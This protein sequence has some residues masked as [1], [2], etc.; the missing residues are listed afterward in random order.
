MRD[1]AD[2]ILVVRCGRTGGPEIYGMALHTARFC[3]A[4]LLATA[5]NWFRTCRASSFCT[6]AWQLAIL[7]LRRRIARFLGDS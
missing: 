4:S 1:R 5:D 2:E 6:V 7:Q 3:R